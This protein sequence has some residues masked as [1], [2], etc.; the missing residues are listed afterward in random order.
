MHDLIATGS[1]LSVDPDRIVIKRL[2]LS[3][4]PFKIFTKT[5]VVRYMFFNRG[6]AGPCWEK[7]FWKFRP[8]GYVGAAQPVPYLHFVFPSPEDVMWFK[9]VELRTKWGRRG[10]IKEPLGRF[11]LVFISVLLARCERL[12]MASS[13]PCL[14]TH[15]H[16][17]CHFDGQLKS[18][19]TVL[20]NLYKRVFPKWTYDPHVP[21]PVPWVRSESTLPEREMEME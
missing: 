10:H 3:G 19:D 18:Q 16:M 2:V 14:G 21:E 6:T 5:A 12:L 1:L 20:L 4:H 8:C 13:A 15:G 9:P 7:G 17:K 11:D